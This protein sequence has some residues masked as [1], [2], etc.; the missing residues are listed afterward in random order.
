MK[1]NKNQTVMFPV[2]KLNLEIHNF[3]IGPVEFLIKYLKIISF[4]Y[5]LIHLLQLQI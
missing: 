3:Q 4:T 5:M 1:S 2:D